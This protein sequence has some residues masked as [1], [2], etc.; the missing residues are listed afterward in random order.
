M[1]KGAGDVFREALRLALHERRLWPA[2]LLV[3]VG[4]ADCWRIIFD[5]GPYRA[6]EVAANRVR[7]GGG[8]GIADIVVM[9]LVALAVFA[10]LRAWGYAGELVLIGQAASAAKGESASIMVNYARYRK[11]YLSLSAVLLPWD[12]LRVAVIYVTFPFVFLWEKWD[13]HLRL[14][15]PY[16]LAFLSWLALLALV[17]MPLGIAVLLAGRAAVLGD[18]PSPVAWREGWELFRANAARCCVAWFQALAVDVAFI[19]PAWLLAALLPWAFTQLLRAVSVE[20]PRWIPRAAAYLVLAALLLPG[21]TLV[22]CFKSS[23]WTMTFLELREE[24]EVRGEEVGGRGRDGRRGGGEEL[25]YPPLT[26]L[27]MP[28]PGPAP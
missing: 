2:G 9:A 5:W 12:A 3:A 10:L 6:G 28:P 24:R 15:L 16:L 8:R 23:L 20:A 17:Y 18:K 27:P 26:R 25:I 7:G 22:Q 11:R 21:Q 19:V 13:P 1:E 4:F 14:F